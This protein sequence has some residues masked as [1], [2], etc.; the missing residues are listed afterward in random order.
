MMN[1]PPAWTLWLMLLPVAVGLGGVILLLLFPSR[2]NSHGAAR[3]ARPGEVKSFYKSAGP[4]L[5]RD[6]KGKLLRA[7]GDA[8]LITIAPP[9]SEKGGGQIIPTLLLETGSVIV[10]DPKGEAARA[11]A[12]HREKFGP[13]HIIDPFGTTGQPGAKYNPL[14][15]LNASPTMIEDAFQIAEAIVPDGEGDNPHFAD[16]ARDLIRSIIL[17][18]CQSYPE[19]ERHLFTLRQILNQPGEKLWQTLTEMSFSPLDAINGPARQQ[20]AREA[21]EAAGMISTAGRNTGWLDS[22]AV[23]SSLEKSDF[24]FADLKNE[25]GTVFIVLPPTKIASF[26]RWLRLITVC[27]IA[28]FER[29]P[30][31]QSGCLFIVDE[32]A[33][34]GRLRALETAYSV[35]TGYGLRTWSFWQNVHQLKSNGADSLLSASG[36]QIYSDVADLD[37]A[38]LVSGNLG[39]ETVLIGKKPNIQRVSRP[40]LAP[41]LVR[42]ERRLIIF[43]R[44]KLAVR[45]HKIRWWEDKQMAGLGHNERS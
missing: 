9:R 30:L 40:L 37:T 4:V 8:P 44:G 33:A 11:T 12:S 35:M 27:V 17:H 14:A 10:I 24:C 16:G 15:G 6:G 5:G 3:W 34:L 7:S 1:A 21:K 45:A 42:Q 26:A 38:K 23:S 19:G 22:V 43:E 41:E 18:I 29:D 25:T 2:P 32:A 36:T 39:D 28:D 20:L 13:V 31:P